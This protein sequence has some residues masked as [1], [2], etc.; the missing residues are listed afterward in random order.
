MPIS[1]RL[2]LAALALAATGV[3]A[4][5]GGCATNPVTGGTDI[6]T[7]S[8][9]Q[10]IELGRKMHPQILQQYGRFDDEQLQQYVSEVGQRIA[11]AFARWIAPSRTK[12]M[13]T[14]DRL[15]ISSRSRASV[16]SSPCCAFS[17]VMSEITAIASASAAVPLPRS[18]SA[19][20]RSGCPAAGS[21]SIRNSVS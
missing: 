14:S 7:M 3:L 12:A 16:S 13:P 17:R 18:D 2:K 11:E 21:A 6:V 1:P 20:Q 5:L 10:E 19:S 8:E 9:A 4:G 15:N